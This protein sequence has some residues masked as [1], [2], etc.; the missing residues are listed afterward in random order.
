[1]NN[2]QIDKHSAY[3]ARQW[4]EEMLTIA[5]GQRVSSIICAYVGT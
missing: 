1:M 2:K 5:E 3:F 4:L